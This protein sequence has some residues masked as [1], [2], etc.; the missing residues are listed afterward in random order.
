MESP[1]QSRAEALRNAVLRRPNSSSYHDASNIDP[2]RPKYQFF[3]Y[4]SELDPE[5]GIDKNA[6]KTFIDDN[7]KS[8]ETGDFTNSVLIKYFRNLGWK[9]KEH[10]IYK[11]ED[12][13]KP[14][15]IYN[16]LTEF[17]NLDLPKENE[18]NINWNQMFERYDKYIPKLYHLPYY[19]G[20]PIFHKN[21]ETDP[22][23]LYE[24]EKKQYFGYYMDIED[25]AKKA[26]DDRV[27]GLNKCYEHYKI[28]RAHV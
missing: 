11:F 23:G 27:E 3:V 5:H 1:N 18:F 28:G 21:N 22:D 26:L 19:D 7:R 24:T 6:L 15:V 16:K 13:R 9:K 8:E 12:I 17:M 2:D 20:L 4:S 10:K 14:D 25:Q